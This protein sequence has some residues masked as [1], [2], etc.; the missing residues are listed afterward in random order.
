[1]TNFVNYVLILIFF[2][3]E[4][5]F[6]VHLFPD[7]QHPGFINFMKILIKTDLKRL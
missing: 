7:M 1:M 5:R 6:R 2:I 4:Y 3:I